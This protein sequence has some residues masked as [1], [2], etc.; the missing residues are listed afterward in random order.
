MTRYNARI[1]YATRE[2]VDDHLIHALIDYH[3]ATGRSP[4]GW[5]EVTITLPSESLRQA[6]V[7][8]LALAEA[9]L[10]VD[11]LALE[12]LPTDEFDARLGL[13]PLPEIV[14]VTEAAEKLGVSRSAV[15]KRL[16]SGSL[17]GQKAG[18]TWVVRADAVLTPK[19]R[20]ER[21]EAGHA[22]QLAAI[23]ELQRQRDQTG[24]Q[25]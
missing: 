9:A 8:A 11:V 23:P 15:L 1:E 17:P 20:R 6:T 22:E 2:P 10:A 25:D 12:V 5:A 18:S 14:S 7:T 19:E 13:T 3:P 16:E 4:R 24:G 21:L